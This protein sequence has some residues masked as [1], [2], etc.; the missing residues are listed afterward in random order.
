MKLKGKKIYVTGF[1]VL[2]V[3]AGSL[4]ILNK[5]KNAG[6]KENT[7]NIASNE[8]HGNDKK[9]DH[10]KEMKE[11]GHRDNDKNDKHNENEEDSKHDEEDAVKIKEGELLEFGIEVVKAETGE[12]HK[13]INLTGEIIVIP[14]RLAHIVPRFPGIV[15][16]V[17]KKIGDR[18]YRGEVLAVIESNE[19]LAIYNLRS[20]IS[21]TVINMHITRGEVI[22]DIDSGHGF[23]IAD[24]RYVW[25]NLNVY[26][27]DLGFISRRQKVVVTGPGQ[28]KIT[29]RISYI[30]P[31]VNEKTRTATARVVI[32]NRKGVWRPGIF[33]NATVLTG[34]KRISILIP[35][36]AIFNFKNKTVVFIKKDQGFR[37]QPVLTGIFN[38]EYIE[39]RSGLSRGEE[40]ASRGGFTIKAEFMKESFGGGHG[41]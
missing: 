18:V 38:N 21:G 22:S 29:G 4:F 14:D 32:N 17:R 16:S 36:T 8:N 37:S 24:L 40:Y 9:D 39:I 7:E 25:A 26:Q 15:K 23:D 11:N 2:L 30:S 10:I 28:Q 27:K 35:K 33:V 1:I 34:S 13:Y 41:H 31:N 3:F 6:Y 19:S 5:N 20:L 12:L